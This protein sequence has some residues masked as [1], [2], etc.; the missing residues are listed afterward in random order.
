M[1]DYQILCQDGR[2]IAKETGIFIKEERNKITK[3]DV[4]LKSLSSLV[5]Y[6]DKTAESQIVEQLR[7]LI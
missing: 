6:V 4:K 5:T 7:N 2:K 3:S 1:N